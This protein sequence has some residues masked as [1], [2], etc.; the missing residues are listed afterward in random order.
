PL[1]EGSTTRRI[2]QVRA[3]GIAATAPGAPAAAALTAGHPERGLSVLLHHRSLDLVAGHVFTSPYQLRAARPGAAT[4]VLPRL[5]FG[6]ELRD[7]VERVAVQRVVH[8]AAL[9]P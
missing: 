8:P 3:D 7:L 9:P 5:H 4:G 2:V 6:S 1:R